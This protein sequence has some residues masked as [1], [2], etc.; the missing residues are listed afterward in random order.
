MQLRY[1]SACLNGL[2]HIDCYCKEYNLIDMRILLWKII[3]HKEFVPY[4]K[5]LKL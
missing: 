4:F 1:E 3:V 2:R 5:V